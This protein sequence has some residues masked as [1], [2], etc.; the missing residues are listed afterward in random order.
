VIGVGGLATAAAWACCLA[1]NAASPM[2]LVDEKAVIVW[3]PDRQ[4]EHFVRQAAF[5]GEAQD[6]GFIVPAPTVPTVAEADG[7]VFAG[8]ESFV[9]SKVREPSTAAD[10]DS[11]AAG[12]ATELVDQYLVGDYEVSILK[13]KDGASMLGWLKANNYTNRPAMEDWLD[14][15]AKMGWHFAALKFVR[16]E[17]AGTPGTKAVR[18]SFKTDVPFYPYKMP[19]DT[20]PPGHF[21]PIALYFVSKGIARGQYRGS[22]DDWEA[23]EVWSGPL[24]RERS[25]LLAGQ[26]GLNPEDLPEEA[27]LTA[28]YN[29]RNEAGYENDVYFLTYTS[30]LPTWAVLLVFGVGVALIVWWLLSRRRLRLEA[31]E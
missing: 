7:E 3:D 11:V 6:F 26:I 19:S 1:F 23:R 16:A 29:T 2:S 21:R 10:T 30:V 25:V 18:V 8:L 12:A 17:D 31:S 14:H 9:S 15:Y 4:M 24:G 27:T 28:F 13:A 20:W 5:E 22:G